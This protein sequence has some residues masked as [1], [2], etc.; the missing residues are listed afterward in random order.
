MCLPSRDPSLS[1]PPLMTPGHRTLNRRVVKKENKKNLPKKEKKKA[2]SVDLSSVLVLQ[3][4]RK[5]NY[6]INF[7]RKRGLSYNFMKK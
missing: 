1:Y 4:A 7:P 3:L 2:Q 5:F 6:M